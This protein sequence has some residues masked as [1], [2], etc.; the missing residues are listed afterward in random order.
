MLFPA[1][2]EQTYLLPLSFRESDRGPAIIATVKFADL[3]PC[4]GRSACKTSAFD[5][6]D[7][8]AT[9]LR[10]TSTSKGRPVV[11]G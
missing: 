11:V 6:A 5:F 3:R 9:P 7:R 10:L 1:V 8:T 4:G 2:L